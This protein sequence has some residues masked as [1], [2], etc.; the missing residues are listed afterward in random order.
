MTRLDDRLAEFLVGELRGMDLPDAVRHLL[1]E[2]L[3][4]RPGC[5]RRLIRREVERLGREGVPRCEA[6]EAVA[7]E[8]C[9]SYEKVRNAFYH[10]YRPKP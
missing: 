10:P 8:R 4:H 1:R 3:L 9:C 5:E 6:F 7:V 2:G